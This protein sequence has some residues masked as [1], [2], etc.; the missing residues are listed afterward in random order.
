MLRKFYTVLLLLLSSVVL[1][2]CN[3]RTVHELYCLPMRSEEYTNLQSVMSKAMSGYEYSAPL[4]GENQQTVQSADLN[5]DG[6]P[7]YILFAKG[8]SEK[9]MK[10][11]VFSGD[12]ETYTLVDTI[13]STGSA[14]DQVEYIQ[15]DEVPGYELVVG[16]QVSDQVVRS[17]SVYSMGQG[18]MEQ[19]ISANYTEFICCDMDANGKSELFVLGPGDGAKGV[20]TLYRTVNGILER[21]QEVNMSESS[22]N[23]KRIM[24]SKLNDGKPAVY[25]AS[26]VT[27]SDGI[28]TDVYAI[29]DGQLTNVSFSNESGTSVQTLRNYYVYADDIDNDGVL[30]LPSLITTK[31]TAENTDATSQ[32]V[33][34]WYAMT[35]DGAEVDK[36]Y[37][38]HNYAGRWYIQLDGSIAERISVTHKGSS[39][40]FS[41]WNEDFTEATALMTVYALTGQ[42]REEQAVADN[43]FVLYRS[44]STIYAA[45]LGVA[46]ADLGM[47][48]ESLIGS[49]YLILED[50]KTGET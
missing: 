41:L 34:R 14:F 5:G 20:A 31:S 30:E 44:E 38:Y 11:F 45:N 17:V 32:Y 27:G 3:M 16:R 26:A 9:P 39:Y 18:Q 7:E 4:N 19:L 33:I 43:R 37:T 28:I 40:E 23:I 2:G 47:T 49:F 22:D 15:M 12:G 8:T 36:M 21:S 42:K 13:E 1:G 24:V 46:S 50:W 29:V 48:K 6:Q 25:V 35:A 10:I